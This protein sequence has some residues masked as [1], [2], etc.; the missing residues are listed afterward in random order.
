MSNHLIIGLGGTGGKVIRAFRKTI[1]QEFR[2]TEPDG[3]NVGYLYVDSDNG[4]MAPDDP[5]WKILGRLVQL[6]KNQQVCIQGANLQQHLNNIN[7]FPGIKPWIGNQDQWN[8]ILSSFQGVSILGGQKRRLGRFLFACNTADFVNQ[9]T[10]QVTG[11]HR[12]S[13]KNDVTFHVCCGLAGGTGSGIIIDVLA[14]IRQHFQYNDENGHF[15]LI[16]YALL[17]EKNPKQGWDTGNYHANGYAALLELNALSA[18]AFM[19][20]DISSGG[21]VNSNSVMFNGLYLFTNENEQGSVLDV[22]DEVP[23]MMADFL[24]QKIVAVREL[25]WH[26]LRRAE[27]MENG[28]STP[29]TAPI[30]GSQIP[31]RA[32]RFLTFG[33]KRV[34]IPDEEIKEYLS[35]QFARQVALH[36]KFNNWDDTAGFVERPKNKDFYGFVAEKATQS[37]WLLSDDHLCLSKAILPQD[38][39]KNWNTID[40]DWQR[41]VPSFTSIVRNR[42]KKTWLEELPKL[43]AARFDKHFRSGGRGEVGGVQQFYKLKQ[44][45]LTQMAKE[46]RQTIEE[47]LFTDWKNGRQSIYD[48]V[49]LGEALINSLDKRRNAISAKIIQRENE[50]KTAQEN[51]EEV[52][53]KWASTWF[54]KLLNAD[55]MLDQQA[56]NLRDLYIARTWAQALAFSEKLMDVLLEEIRRF[57]VTLGKGMNIVTK[58]VEEF[59]TLLSQ[60]I[61]DETQVDITKQLVRFYDPN[62]VRAVTNQLICN[63]QVQKNCA[64]DVRSQVISKMGQTPTFSIFAGLDVSS[65]IDTLVIQSEQNAQREHDRHVESTKRL[66][67][68]SI[69]EKLKVDYDNNPQALQLYVNEL[70]EHACNY[71]SFSTAEVN[72]QGVGIPTSPTRFSLFTVILPQ[73]PEH[74]KFL[75][76]LKE[77]FQSAYTGDV[78]FLY[79]DNKPNEIAMVNITNLFPLRFVEGV[80]F[81]RNKYVA[82]INQAKDPSRSILEVHTEDNDFPNLFVPSVEEIEKEAIPYLLL[83]KI[84]GLIVLIDNPQTGVKQFA[85]MPQ[86]D[87]PEDYPPIYLGKAFVDSFKELDDLVH[88]ETIKQRVNELL[89]TAYLHRD[90]RDTLADAMMAEVRRIK[91]EECGNNLENLV[92]KRFNEGRK[93]ALELLNRG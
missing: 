41:V 32:K 91:K 58:S 72:R 63:E 84:M 29:E 16:A 83:A 24:Y 3:V 87:N 27:N 68:V 9:L 70:V 36:L 73:A 77:A 71:L 61:K 76:N 51:I 2:K 14:Q 47:T 89:E 10:L 86:P 45:A 8:D 88:L 38:I 65:F 90:K 53:K 1:F 40:D 28:E 50:A 57:Q 52:N 26:G 74:Q 4:M 78:Q 15:R 55:N 30:P 46:I 67:G 42:P 75:D 82:K 62:A 49:A 23:D 11:L 25:S 34:A 48:I 7:A 20:Y 19:P 43:F 33:I 85:F 66:V 37:D 81:L 54:G 22:N 56:A 69:I 18:G 17:P 64:T 21:R 31:E 39:D 44:E 5:S 80:N 6:G 12:I 13:R 60:R 93:T 92:Y 35:Y 59:D 79:S